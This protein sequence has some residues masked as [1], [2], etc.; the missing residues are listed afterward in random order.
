MNHLN[1]ASIGLLMI[2]LVTTGVISWFT[3]RRIVGVIDRSSV[4]RWLAT[5]GLSICT[6]MSIAPLLGQN[7]VWIL[8]F[9]FAGIWLSLDTLHRMGENATK[10]NPKLVSGE[11]EIT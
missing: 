1:V 5:F 6:F 4:H 7:Q 11:S 3:L 10:Q 9:P 2:G 8:L